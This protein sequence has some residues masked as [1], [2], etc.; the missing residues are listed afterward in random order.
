MRNSSITLFDYIGVVLLVL[1]SDAICFLYVL[2]PFLCF[3]IFFVFSLCRFLVFKKRG[4]FTISKFYLY[5]YSLSILINMYFIN[6]NTLGNNGLAIFVC[7]WGS[8]FFYSTYTFEKFRKIYLNIIYVITILGVPIYLL[9]EAGLLPVS[10]IITF[11]GIVRTQFLFFN[12]GWESLHGRFS[13]IWHEAGA[14]MIFLNLCILLYSND[15]RN[16]IVD[17]KT[18]YKLII[19]S[20]GI[21]ATQSTTGYLVFICILI[22][23]FYPLIVKTKSFIK[24]LYLILLVVVVYMLANS[25]TIV[26]KFNQDSSESAE[27][28]FAVRKMDNLS[29]MTMACEK[30]LT[31]YGYQTIEFEERAFRLGNRS[32]SNGI[33]YI[34]A[35]AGIWWIVL[36]LISLYKGCRSVSIT[37]PLFFMLIIILMQCNERFVEL[38]ISYLFLAPFMKNNKYNYV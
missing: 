21:I 32:S 29:L 7:L 5:I 37:H 3:L 30:P 34:S 20:L 26:N 35:C 16:R 9:C 38:P 4:F 6:T 15:I 8:Y 27:T 36:Y 1:V 17:K 24:S 11:D 10:K 28:S 33:L 14:C 19:V 22:Y 13:G 31:G 2:K 18:K 25:N 12:V 23:C